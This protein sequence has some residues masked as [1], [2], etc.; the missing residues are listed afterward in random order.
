MH[1]RENSDDYDDGSDKR[2][3]GLKLE[4]QK[5]NIE[6]LNN[7]VAENVIGGGSQMQIHFRS[8]NGARMNVSLDNEEV[9]HNQTTDPKA[10]NLS[11]QIKLAE[12]ARMSVDKQSNRKSREVR[13]RLQYKNVDIDQ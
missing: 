10:G 5:T 6:M 11:H 9:L 1:S 3:Q 2:T 4:N 8:P 12:S 13:T 7:K